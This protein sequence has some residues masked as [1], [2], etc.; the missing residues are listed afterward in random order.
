MTVG[1]TGDILAGL[2][3][4]F[5]ARGNTGFDAA[6]LALHWLCTTAD[7]LFEEYGPC[8]KPE[9]ILER[10]PHVLRRQLRQLNDWPPVD[11]PTAKSRNK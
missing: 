5:V 2:I 10:M 3:C 11:K 4:G 9:D 7:E 6:R 1:G 8:Y